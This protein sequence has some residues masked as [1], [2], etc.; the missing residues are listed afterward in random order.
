M[1]RFER[2]ILHIPHASDRL[3]EGC[4]WSGNIRK[5]L[6]RWTDWHTDT[7]FDSPRSDVKS[8]VYQWSRF[9]CDIERLT[10]D[11]MESI[12]Q[13]IAYRTI[14]GC[15]RELN[16]LDIHRIYQSYDNAKQIF[17]DLTKE[18]GSLIIDCHSFPSDMAPGIDICIGFNEDETKPS[19]EV[20]NL[21]IEHFR[22]AGY[23]VGINEPY[24]NSVCS[25]IVTQGPQTKTIMIEINKAVYLKSDG[26]TPSEDFDKIKQLIDNLYGKLL[27]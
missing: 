1:D 22:I 6:D 2:I 14:D 3:P 23:R 20:I 9:Y 15:L 18:S 5:A 17:Y 27:R 21:I 13:G 7:L 8:F 26:T 16:D 4:N 11:P 24:S 25:L 12:G 10:N 19:D